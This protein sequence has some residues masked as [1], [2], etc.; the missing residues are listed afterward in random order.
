MSGLAVGFTAWTKNDGLLYVFIFSAL[1]FLEFL[2]E[3]IVNKKR[4]YSILNFFIGLLPV[5][6]IVLLFKFTVAPGNDLTSNR[7]LTEIL[8]KILDFERMETIIS[9]YA[10][11]I[12]VMNGGYLLIV[13]LTTLVIFGWA[14]VSKPI[15]LPLKI[16]VLAMLSYFMV[17]LVT[18]KDLV[19]HITFSL[20]RLLMHLFPSVIFCLWMTIK[21]DVFESERIFLFS[22]IKATILKIK[23][24]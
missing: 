24:R 12:G 4:D 2:H 18:P 14:G 8:G 13:Y 17:Y 6:A 22:K 20:T 21:G 15:A 1:I 7:N 23:Q 5:L 11:R 3:L 9:M 16:V 19:W 10:E